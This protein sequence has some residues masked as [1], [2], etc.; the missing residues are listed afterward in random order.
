VNDQQ[1]SIEVKALVDA[2][3]SS[4]KRPDEG[5][6]LGKN[7][8]ILLMSAI[9]A[10]GALVWSVVAPSAN[11]TDL[12]R[13]TAEIRTTVLEMRTMFTDLSQKLDKSQAAQSEQQAKLVGLEA[14]VTSNSDNIEKL[15]ERL[16]D[17]ERKW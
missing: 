16:S 11:I 9:G 17:M 14:K 10:A 2:I 1:H 3:T 12:S 8:N 15:S 5:L 13:Q 6:A 4:N 7:V